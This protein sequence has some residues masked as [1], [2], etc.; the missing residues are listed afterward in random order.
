M[1][2]KTCTSDG[3]SG[4]RWGD[5]GECYTGPGAKKKALK[6]GVAIELSKQKEGK[7]SEFDKSRSELMYEIQREFSF[8]EQLVIAQEIR[9]TGTVQDGHL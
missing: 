5:S 4:Y 1:P 9:K 2:L 6:Q 3:K 8:V 7:P